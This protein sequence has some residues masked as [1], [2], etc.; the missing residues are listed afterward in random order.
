MSVVVAPN[1]KTV[2]YSICLSA[3]C[4]PGSGAFNLGHMGNLQ[5]AHL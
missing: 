1:T 3:V 2:V 4:N 5:S